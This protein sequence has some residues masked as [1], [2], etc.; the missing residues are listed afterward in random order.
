MN[1]VVFLLVIS[2]FL[3]LCSASTPKVDSRLQQKVENET[4][5]I[6]LILEEITKTEIF[7]D[8]T[9]RAVSL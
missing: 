3:C 8:A 7:A 6:N 4:I 9:K 2:L 1:K 5:E